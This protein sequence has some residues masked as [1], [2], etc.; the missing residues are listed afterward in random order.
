MAEENL[1]AATPKTE[2]ESKTESSTKEWFRLADEIL[3]STEPTTEPKTE[4]KTKSTPLPKDWIKL[5]DGT[6][7]TCGAG[8]DDERTVWVWLDENS[9]M[10]MVQAFATFSDETKTSRIESYYRN[11]LLATWE[12]YTRL[13]DIKQND[14]GV[15]NIGLRKPM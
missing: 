1:S 7:V 4:D 8:H 5:A 14:N 3:N 13:F 2:D 9:G 12:G 15:I 6:V 10:T 11:N